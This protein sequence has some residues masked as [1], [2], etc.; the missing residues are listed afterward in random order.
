MPIWRFTQLHHLDHVAMQLHHVDHV[1]M[2]TGIS[3]KTFCQYLL[4]QTSRLISS[5]SYAQGATHVCEGNTVSTATVDVQA[6]VSILARR[7]FLVAAGNG[8]LRQVGVKNED[9]EELLR[10]AM[11]LRGS[12]GRKASLVVK[13]RHVQK[14]PSIQ[15]PLTQTS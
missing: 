4:N 10:Q 9:Q 6:R 12:I 1:A 11:M 3:F 2:I 14:V 7:D 8:N 15:K 13:H 5:L